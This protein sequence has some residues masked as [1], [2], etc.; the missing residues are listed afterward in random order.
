MCTMSCDIRGMM[1][2]A[3]SAAFL[4][5]IP[6]FERATQNKIER[7]WKAGQRTILVA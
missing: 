6:Q 2:G 5:P 7:A 3:F 1:S 4:N